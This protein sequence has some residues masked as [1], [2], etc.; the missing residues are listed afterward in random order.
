M[1]A[2]SIMGQNA[3]TWKPLEGKQ[4]AIF[5]LDDRMG[6]A[7]TSEDA[8]GSGLCFSESFLLKITCC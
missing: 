5:G 4:A 6:M 7:S 2:F 3:A 8:S 1:M